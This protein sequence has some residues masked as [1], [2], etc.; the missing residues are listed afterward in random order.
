MTS[1]EIKYR[2]TLAHP[3]LH[4]ESFSNLKFFQTCKKFMNICG[5]ADNFGLTDLGAPTKARFRRQLS[6]AINYLK[7]KEDRL[8]L[9]NEL[10]IQREE[11]L[12]GLAEVNQEHYKWKDMI[13]QA[14]AEAETRWDEAKQIDV[15]CTEME[16]EIAQQNK[17][18]RS[19]RGESEELKKQASILKDKI[20][21]A[22]LGLQEMEAE[23]RHLLPKIVDSPDELKMKLA[24]LNVE[25]AQEQRRAKEAEEELKTMKF[26]MDN[27]SKAKNDV[28]AATKLAGELVEEEKKQQQISGE[29]S[30]IQ[31][32]I[33]TNEQEVKRLEQLRDNHRAEVESI[34][35]HYITTLH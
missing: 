2:Q 8:A 21:T 3:E 4:E 17:L 12:V 35:K 10:H 13:L 34:G 7:Y 19:L 26:R 22:A 27:V 1:T 24:E 18:Q 25:L 30:G 29:A 5:N 14:K 9:W 33:D 31:R 6:A 20:D 11:L 15:D 32:E 28:S 16:G 23:E